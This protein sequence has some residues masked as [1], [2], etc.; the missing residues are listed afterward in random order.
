M[1]LAVD[2]LIVPLSYRSSAHMIGWPGA[3]PAPSLYML[4]ASYRYAPLLSPLH[5]Q[6]GLVESLLS[7]SHSKVLCYNLLKRK[8][9]PPQGLVATHAQSIQPD[10]SKNTSALQ[11]TARPFT[12]GRIS[13]A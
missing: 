4:C 12:S 1:Y 2:C 11:R 8:A 13:S 7:W 5:P 9:R 6:R 10:I 3:H